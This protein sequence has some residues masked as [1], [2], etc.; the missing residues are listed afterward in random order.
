M[1]QKL[2]SCNLHTTQNM[3]DD[4]FSFYAWLCAVCVCVDV[5]K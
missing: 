2:C 3:I 4:K 1:I 5:E